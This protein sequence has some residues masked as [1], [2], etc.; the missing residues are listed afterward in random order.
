MASLSCAKGNMQNGNDK[1]SVVMPSVPLV[2]EVIKYP[3]FLVLRLKVTQRAILAHR[4]V[5]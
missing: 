2:H 1:W 4:K 3:Y 5:I